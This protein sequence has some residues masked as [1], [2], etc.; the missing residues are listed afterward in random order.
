MAIRREWLNWNQPCLSQAAGWLIDHTT[1]QIGANSK[2]ICDL[3][4]VICVLPGQRAGR[5]L[6]GELLAQ[7][8]SRGMQLI[9]PRLVTPGSLTAMLA[10]DQPTANELETTLAWMEALQQIAEADPDAIRPIVPHVPSSDDLLSWREL[11]ALIARV[12][13]DLAG[14]GIGFSQVADKAERMEMFAEGD[15]WRSLETVHA[16]FLKVLKKHGLCDAHDSRSRAIASAATFWPD[17]QQQFILIAVTELNAVQR[18]LIGSLSERV[19]ALIHAPSDISDRFDDLGCI[20]V[21]TWSQVQVGVKDEQIQV[22]D[23]P[24]DQSAAVL[25]AIAALDGK[26]AAEQFT[27]GVGDESAV[28]A[29][30]RHA[31]W[32]GLSV[33]A[34]MGKPLAQ[35]GPLRFLAAAAQW[36]SEPRFANFASLVR[37][38]D[39][40]RWTDKTLASQGNL[41]GTA[42][43]A[44]WLTLLDRYFSDHLQERLT[45]SWLGNAKYREG[46]GAVYTA[47]QR[48]LSPLS[49]AS[50]EHSIS[51]WGIA[52][53]EVLGELYSSQTEGDSFDACMKFRESI[54]ETADVPESLQPRTTASIA[55]HFLLLL[56]QSTAQVDEPRPDAIELLGWLELHLDPAPALIITGFNEGCVPQSTPPGPFLP[57]SLRS[58]LGLPNNQQRYARDAY[59]LEA[60]RHSR[61]SLTII[62]GRHSAQGDPLAP[63]R[64]LLACE[65]PALVE[66]VRAM[67]DEPTLQ[68]RLLP[69]GLCPGSSPPAKTLFTI[70]VLPHL[71]PPVRMRVTEFRQYLACPYRYALGCLL[72]L[73]SFSDGSVELDPLAFGSLAHDVLCDF[74]RDDEIKASASAAHIESLLFD[75]LQKRVAKRFGPS[76]MPAVQVQIAHL[77]QRLR[78]FSQF[79]SEHRKQGW[80]IRHCEHKIDESIPLDIP[81]QPPMPLRGTIDRIDI[82]ERTGDVLIMDYKTSEAGDS[83]HKTHHGR[84]AINGDLEWTDLQLPLYH[85]LATR[86][87]LGISSAPNIELAYI[88]LPKQSDGVR[89]LAAKWQQ[90][91]L[92][93]AVETARDIVRKI[94]DNQFPINPDFAT[95]FDDFSRICQTTVFTGEDGDGEGGAE[96]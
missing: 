68:L 46:L 65:G 23:R 92:H 69:L 85:Y 61:E 2:S 84:E 59:L 20:D 30:E 37:H 36:L 96:E 60:I 19:T 64:L 74:G 51:E 76:P 75:S 50:Q 38:P 26:Y 73:E 95:P 17:P 79:Q 14:G 58:A 93:A 62:L 88:T 43:V 63:S 35:S 9:P 39:V 82:N 90:E 5:L 6:L 28:P 3:Q 47:V 33:R 54:A 7:T 34:A 21:E 40:E 52:A 13:S 81:G 4:H 31:E 12:H 80:L 48:L 77:Q 57:D 44:D 11:A 16:Q 18:V 1:G 67:C 8:K 42:A 41:Q 22:V 83:P 15:R 55:L 45:G 32:A 53:L 94:R 87:Q 86:A 70:P 29:I 89:L 91:H 49:R 25:A 56:S 27:I 78:S 66:R 72:G 71:P 10:A 24:S